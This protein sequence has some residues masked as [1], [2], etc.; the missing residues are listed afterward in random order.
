MLKKSC[1][2]RQLFLHLYVSLK[3]STFMSR[4][5]PFLP[6]LSIAVLLCASV[7]KAE[8]APK[9]ALWADSV[10]QT[11]TIKQKIAQLF[12]V[13]AYSNKP[14]SH[15]QEMDQLVGQYEIGGICFFQG[16]PRKQAELTN[17]YQLQAHIPLL[18]AMDAEWGV[19]M[20]LDSVLLFPKQ[21]ALG[22]IRDHQMIYEMGKEVGRQFKALGMHLN[23]APVVDINNNP[24]NPVINTRSFGEE[25]TE[26]AERA[27]LYMK[28]MQDEGILTCAKHFPGHG[29]T[30]VDSHL[31]L[32]IIEYNRKRLDSLELYPFKKIVRA[33]V[34]GVMVGHLYVPSI[35]PTKGIPTSLSPI[36][37]QE[38]LQKDLHF[39]GIVFSDGMQMKAISNN[40]PAPIANLKALQAGCD[41][42]V[43]PTHVIESI[44]TIAAAVA[45]N[46]FPLSDL[47]AKCKKIL[48][49]KYQLHLNHF[50]PIS[51]QNI[52]SF[53]NRPQAKALQAALTESSLLLM[54]NEENGIPLNNA[55]LDSCAYLEIGPDSGLPFYHRLREYADI[56]RISVTQK[57]DSLV[58][59]LPKIRQYSTLI[60]GYH[61]LSE[62]PQRKFRVDST[63]AKMLADSL[64]SQR[65]ILVLFGT[66][67]T[68]AKLPDARNF[69]S[70]LICYNNH[71]ITQDKAAQAL[72]GGIEVNG[73]QPVGKNIYEAKGK[74][75]QT[76]ITRLSY[77]S[78][79]ELGIPQES[80][81]SIDSL[82][83]VGL[84]NKAYPGCQVLAAYD[85]KVFF[86][87]A[88]GKLSYADSTPANL[89][90]MYDVASISKVTGTLGV[91][92]HL[93]D[94]K[95]IHLDDPLHLYVK[96]LPD[97]KKDLCLKEL[98]THQ[99]GLIAF[100]PYFA[101]FLVQPNLE[102]PLYA[103]KSSESYP[104]QIGSRWASK[105]AFMNPEFFSHQASEKYPREIGKGVY[106]QLSVR[107]SVYKYMDHSK[108][109]EK[110]YRYSDL[111][112]LY[113]QRVIEAQ[114]GIGLEKWCDSLYFSRLHMYR[115]HYNPALKM[116]VDSIAPTS[117]DPLFRHQTL[118]GY[119]DDNNSA[120]LGGVAGHAGIFSTCNDLAKY[121]QMLL[122]NGSYGGQEFLSKKTVKQFTSQAY[123]H[124]ENRR[125]LGFDKPESHKDKTSPVPSVLSLSSYG[126]TGF[127]GCMVWCDPE[128]KLLFVF[129]SNRVH[130]DPSNNL[131]SK[132]SIRT[133]ILKRL[134]H[135]IDQKQKD[136]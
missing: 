41:M 90:T 92:M 51:T 55:I 91:V 95:I 79:E 46:E 108:P 36:A 10:M 72:M 26:V 117:Y 21:M 99:A 58:K 131:L 109:M 47:D 34:N 112:F 125:A 107:D 57:A 9:S 7:T 15:I 33:G 30:Q 62:Y 124:S 106:S 13:A 27:I 12:M 97:S 94:H 103:S 96:N 134:V 119:V 89:H 8:V 2:F 60:L 11:L 136:E 43:F 116:P 113:L 44:D 81:G 122:W 6:F 82:V 123:K 5:N 63:F 133:E 28:G 78:P 80:L 61:D 20:R 52:T 98:L 4:P 126:H 68:M 14:E 65:K 22:S 100:E 118:K 24:G 59:I 84:A 54:K 86:Q 38:V 135:I 70:I 101:R 50:T 120:M 16:S 83:Q 56:P 87:K 71:V 48:L 127:T 67:Y 18:I 1:P 88:Y 64:A 31:D 77:V 76:H 69:S 45:R 42:L 75:L 35:E 53:L 29:D 19:G 132:F 49:A 110:V 115:T 39:R 104:V 74:N 102:T 3:N 111:S 25:R 114:S 73:T 66:P 93:M 37:I 40:F 23:F 105:D 128:H 85:G 129:L 121:Y 32:P 130:P 17:R